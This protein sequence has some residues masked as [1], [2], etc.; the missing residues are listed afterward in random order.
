MRAPH[1]VDTSDFMLSPMLVMYWLEIPSGVIQVCQWC[2]SLTVHFYCYSLT[3]F[4][5]TWEPPLTQICGAQSVF[6]TEKKKKRYECD[7]CFVPPSSLLRYHQLILL[8]L[9]LSSKERFWDVFRRG[10]WV[11]CDACSTQLMTTV[12]KWAD[13]SLVPYVQNRKFNHKRGCRIPLNS[14]VLCAVI[15]TA[16]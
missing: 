9:F 10:L 15:S 16:I 8:W 13:F 14:A 4:P 6:S 11:I 1:W 3:E 2:V 5:K 12:S 7:T